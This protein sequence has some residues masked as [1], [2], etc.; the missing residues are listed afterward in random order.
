MQRFHRFRAPE[1]GLIP[2]MAYTNKVDVYSFGET[3]KSMYRHGTHPINPEANGIVVNTTR[4]SPVMR[5]T[6]IELL[7]KPWFDDNLRQ[8]VK[9]AIR[10]EGDENEREVPWRTGPMLNLR[11]RRN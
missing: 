7:R 3:L 8:R 1:I 6:V 9:T 5:P 10:T 2:G 11:P 4:N